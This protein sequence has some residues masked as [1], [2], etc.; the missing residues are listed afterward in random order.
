[1]MYFLLDNITDFYAFSNTETIIF[2]LVVSYD[3]SSQR[4]SMHE[5]QFDEFLRPQ[6]KKWGAEERREG[7][8]LTSF[9]LNSL[10]LIDD[11]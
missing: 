10:F 11:R 2:N 4:K 1:M 5:I 6:V 9:I 8:A 3:Y 7:V